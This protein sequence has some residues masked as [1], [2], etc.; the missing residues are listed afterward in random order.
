MAATPAH[1]LDAARELRKHACKAALLHAY[2]VN[3]KR[4]EMLRQFPCGLDGR[5]AIRSSSWV[6]YSSRPTQGHRRASLPPAL[7]FTAP[8]RDAPG[9]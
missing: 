4:R 7:R 6:R 8:F 2:L 5:H 1:K 3:T 9:P